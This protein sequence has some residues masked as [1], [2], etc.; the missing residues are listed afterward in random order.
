MAQLFLRVGKRD[1][2][3]PADLVGAIANEAG[4]PGDS[5]GDI[6]LFDSFSF[7][8]VPQPEASRVQAAL[9]RTTIRGRSPG[10]GRSARAA[11]TP[12]M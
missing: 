3:R 4:I 9:N 11:S 8:E 12:R 2:V 10:V 1:G 6:D 5:I 7:V